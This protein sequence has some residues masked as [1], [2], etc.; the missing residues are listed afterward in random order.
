VHLAD[1]TPSIFAS[2]G[3]VDAENRLE[4]AESPAGRELLFLVDGLGAD[5]IEKYA[6]IIPTIA[7]LTATA[8]LRTSFPSTTATS[9]ATLM[10]G[11]LPGAHGMLGYTVRVP[12]S[13][14]RILNS[15][16]WDERVDP[17][18]WQPLPTLFERAQA[19]AISVTMRRRALLKLY[20]VAR[21]IAVRIFQPISLRKLWQD[22]KQ[23]LH[24]S[25]SM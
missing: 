17:T 1:I 16:K 9:L 20:F 23:L 12:R 15:L 4:I 19:A 18:I 13:G 8:S 22:L 2:L 14:G 21:P 24:L 5:V 11:A 25:I 7:S 10:T 3:L 6:S